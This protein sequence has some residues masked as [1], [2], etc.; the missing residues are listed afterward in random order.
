MRA[1]PILALALPLACVLGIAAPAQAQPR[2]L[3][4]HGAWTAAVHTEGG[5]KI[6]YAFARASKAEG[7]P[8]RAANGVMLVVTH[9]P[10]GRDQVALQSGY[11]YPRQGEGA[12]DPVQLSVGPRTLGFFTAGN[13]A[14]ARENGAAVA[15]FR[16]GR[17][18]V[19][20]GPGPNGRGQAVDTFPLAGFS[21]AYDAISKECPAG[22]GGGGG[23]RR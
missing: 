21:A 6:C 22:G 17:E 9:R 8:G 7:V 16:G 5:Q 3:G 12:T 18:V 19:A 1:L 2:S 15:A 14:F 11:A 10:Q 13:S 23:A 20:K 4:V